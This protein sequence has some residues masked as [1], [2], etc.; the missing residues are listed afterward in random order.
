MS[1]ERRSGQALWLQIEAALSR[2]IGAGALNPGDRLPT[3]PELM[4]RFD[5]S[6]STVRQAIASLE[7]RGLVRAE[8]GRGTFVRGRVLTYPLSRRTRFSR[9]LIEQGF[10]PGME[11]ILDDVL[12][13]GPEVAKKLDIPE[14]QS[15]AHRRAMARADGVPVE[16]GDAWV[17]LNRFP[18]FWT[19]RGRH[20]TVS[21]AF[22]AFGV[23]DYVRKSTLIEARLPTEE[24]AALLEQP[25]ASPVFAVTRLDADL[26]GRPILFGRSIW[27][28]DRVAFDVSL[29]G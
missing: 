28:A 23:R 10:D 17:P 12:P 11:K 24:E 1:L 5:V 9:N 15:V 6:R 26:E 20:A 7:R 16:M 21:A 25:M 18:D 14:W 29:A 13:A 22:A 3:E 27:A 8:Q 4:A 19:V 2:E